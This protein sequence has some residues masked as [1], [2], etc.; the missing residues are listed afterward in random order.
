MLTWSAFASREPEMADAGRA[1]PYQFGVG[2]AFLG[3]ARPDG[4]Q[5]S[6][7]CSP[8]CMMSACSAC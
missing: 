4:V 6:I 2:L 8:S 3:T 1:L 5:E 7:R